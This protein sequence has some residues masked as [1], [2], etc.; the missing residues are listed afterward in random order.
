MEYLEGFKRSLYL[1]VVIQGSSFVPK[2][3]ATVYL[4]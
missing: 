1:G 4:C 3:K 2:L